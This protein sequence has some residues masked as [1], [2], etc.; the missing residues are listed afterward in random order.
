M[1]MGQDKA[2]GVCVGGWVGVGGGSSSK[3]DLFLA[4]IQVHAKTASSCPFP[5]HWAL[6]QLP[7]APFMPC[8]E[9]AVLELSP[10]WIH[11]TLSCL[12][13]PSGAYALLSTAAPTPGSGNILPAPCP[14]QEFLASWPL[15]LCS[16]PSAATST[17]SSTRLSGSVA[18]GTTCC[19]CEARG[20]GAAAVGARARAAGTALLWG[21]AGSL[22]QTVGETA[23]FA[24]GAQDVNCSVISKP[25]KQP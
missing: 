18:S 8:L 15:A 24:L 3:R 9:T 20:L 16:S 1:A 22:P 4:R 23:R 14:P 19:E 2:G 11:P 12:S 5:S 21:C 25:G 10:A 13:G 6:S 17:T 7:R